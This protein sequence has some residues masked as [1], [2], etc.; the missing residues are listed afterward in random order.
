MASSIRLYNWIFSYNT[1]DKDSVGGGLSFGYPV[2]P[3]T[4]LTVGFA[5][6]IANL[7]L[8]DPENAPESIKVLVA[9]FGSS[10]LVLEV[11]PGLGAMTIPLA[12]R[13]DRIIA[14]EKDT[15]LVRS[16]KEKLSK[17]CITNVTLINDDI[18]RVDLEEI[19]DPPATDIKVMGNLPFNISSPFLEK[20]M[21]H[22]AHLKKA[23]LMF[24]L[25]FAKRLLAS[26]GG[27]DYGAITVLTRYQASVSPLLEVPANAFYPKPKVGSMVVEIDLEKSYPRKAEDEG[28]FKRVVKGAFSHRRKTVFNSLRGS[29]KSYERDEITV[30][31][32]SCSIDPRR[33]AETIDIDEFLNLASALE[34][35]RTEK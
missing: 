6:D 11:G 2:F 8:T 5:H 33:R 27:K 10:D 15:R 4:R 26:P 29:L 22:R 35:N 16:L 7:E 13:V 34:R 9:E 18:L 28:A 32:D 21:N 1:Y 30:A 17:R 12:G 14:V 19:I 23:I 24:Q 25:E 31:L 3:N 20:L